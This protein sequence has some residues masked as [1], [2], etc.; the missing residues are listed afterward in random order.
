MEHGRPFE[1]VLA[2]LGAAAWAVV[3]LGG[4]VTGDVLTAVVG[5]GL[6][7]LSV[8]EI[9]RWQRGQLALGISNRRRAQRGDPSL[10]TTAWWGI[11]GLSA[12]VVLGL[13]WRS[14]QV[15]Q[16]DPRPT[17]VPLVIAVYLVFG[18][19]TSWILTRNHDRRERAV[20]RKPSVTEMPPPP[21]PSPESVAAHTAS[22]PH[23][24]G[25]ATATFYHLQREHGVELDAF[26]PSRTIESTHLTL[27]AR[28]QM[29]ATPE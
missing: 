12:E 2:I 14:I 8:I 26:S 16:A 9:S 28:A 3:G 20:A 25:G 24:T 21:P 19:L 4:V 7:A 18:A 29:P 22:P 10:P 23:E 1:M 15:L 11:G 6:L 13:V 5:V 27:H 17:P